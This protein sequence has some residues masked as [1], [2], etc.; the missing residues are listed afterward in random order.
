M[1]IRKQ[2]PK[3]VSDCQR[4]CWAGKSFTEGEFVKK[5]LLISASELHP[6][7]KSIIENI[8]F[9]RAFWGIAPSNLVGVDRRF[10]AA[11]SH[12]HH[13]GK[14]CCTH[15]WNVGLLHRDYTA[16]Y[17][18]RLSSSYSPPWEPDISKQGGKLKNIIITLCPEIVQLLTL[19]PGTDEKFAISGQVTAF[20]LN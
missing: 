20:V 15:L 16:L 6:D 17:H 12:H 14:G 10:R 13:P 8:S 5:C 19:I 4:N 2:L 1:R 11:D 18:R 9:F 7:K 3:L